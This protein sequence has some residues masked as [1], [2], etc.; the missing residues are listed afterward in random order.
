MNDWKKRKN[1]QNRG[2][3]ARRGPAKPIHSEDGKYWLYGL[4][5]VRAALGNQAREYHRL[6]TTINGAKNLG[7]VPGKP[8]IVDRK[9]IDRLVTSDAVHQ[10][11]ALEVSPL[12]DMP[13]EDLVERDDITCLVVLDQ[14]TD[15]HNVGA[16]MRSAAAFGASAV[17]TT[18]RHSPPETAVLAKA[19]A[20]TLEIMP[21]VRGNN[22]ADQ[23]SKM[24]E[25]GF[26]L[27]GLDASGDTTPEQLMQNPKTKPD[28]IA[29]VLG[30]EGKGLRKRTVDL[31]DHIMRLPIAETV[32]SLNVSN[33]AAVALYAL[34]RD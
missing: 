12:A 5:P 29:L 33:A 20:G 28:R 24:R 9:A 26:I 23:L 18:W 34:T 16:V 22:L 31:C 15:P 30:A 7:D 19:S 21:Y 27:I 10:G 17:I 6:I 1:T 25:A 32:D 13:L 14:V 3:N 4:H 8:E 11:V 2:P